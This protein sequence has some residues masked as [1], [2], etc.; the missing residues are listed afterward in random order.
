M[1]NIQDSIFFENRFVRNKVF[2]YNNSKYSNFIFDS[3]VSSQ[4][5]KV[6][7]IFW[8]LYSAFEK[9]DEI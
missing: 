4:E 5:D 1:M 2:D 6:N 7:S 9:S 8:A 3:E